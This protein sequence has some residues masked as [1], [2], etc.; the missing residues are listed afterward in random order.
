[1]TD[2]LGMLGFIFLTI[3]LYRALNQLDR[4]LALILR[5]DLA[6]L[7]YDVVWAEELWRLNRR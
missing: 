1:M 3:A 4:R 7:G 5:P 6:W 2:S